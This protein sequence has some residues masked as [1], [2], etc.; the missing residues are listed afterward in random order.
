M[1][2]IIGLGPGTGY[3]GTIWEMPRLPFRQM[4]MVYCVRFG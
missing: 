1:W 4:L 2:S 3:L